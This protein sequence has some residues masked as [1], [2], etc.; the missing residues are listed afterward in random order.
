MGKAESSDCRLGQV[1]GMLVHILLSIA[2]LTK[3]LVVGV[4]VEVNAA[5]LPV[6]QPEGAEPKAQITSQDAQEKDGQCEAMAI[7]KITH[8]FVK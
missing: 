2:F 5:C 4:A 3:T 8:M 6:S 1:V 7:S